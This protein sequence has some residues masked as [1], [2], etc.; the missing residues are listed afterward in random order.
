MTVSVTVII[1]S[2]NSSKFIDKTIMS[3]VDQSQKPN[4]I[5]I[6]DDNSNDIEILDK[7]VN[8]IKRNNFKN[9]ELISCSKNNGPGHNRNLAWS[10]CNTDYIAFCDDDDFWYIDKLKKQLTIFE[11]NKNVKLV[12]SQKKMMNESSI[13]K[14]KKDKKYSKLYFYFLIFKNTIPTSSVIVKSDIKDRFLNEYYAEDYYLWLSLLKKRYNCYFINE[15]LCEKIHLNK[16]NLSDKI[17]ELNKGVQ[18][19]LNH[20]YSKNLLNNLIV[21]LAKLYYYLKLTIKIYIKTN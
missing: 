11:Y 19:V 20:F 8:D 17:I 18:N 2:Y 6:I 7:V 16:S 13:N 14:S 15:Y 5:I 9:I 10:K 3:I 1:T 12:A 4:K 21:T